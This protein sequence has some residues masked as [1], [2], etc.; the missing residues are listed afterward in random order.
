MAGL[1][2]S[3]SATQSVIGISVLKNYPDPAPAVSALLH[4]TSKKIHINHDYHFGGY[5]K[6]TNELIQF[7]ND[8]YNSTGIPSDFV[9]T[10]KLFFAVTDLVRK[11]NFTPGSRIM[12][13]HSGGLQGNN[14]LRKG[15]LIF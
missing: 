7:M 12:I 11:K 15:T 2:K 10:A 1:L 8:W 3:S 5:A 9:Y 13:I 14:S 4:D 6:Y